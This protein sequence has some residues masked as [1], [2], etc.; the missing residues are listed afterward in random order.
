MTVSWP[1]QLGNEAVETLLNAKAEDEAV[2][3]G[4]KANHIKHFSLV[5]CVERTRAVAEAI[6][7]RDYEKAISLRSTSFKEFSQ[8]ANNDG[9]RS[10]SPSEA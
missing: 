10:A 2:V 4:T 9:T 6:A 3:V 1:T 5:E 8:Y 7:S